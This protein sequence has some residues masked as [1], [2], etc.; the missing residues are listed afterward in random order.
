MADYIRIVNHPDRDKIIKRL[1]EGDPPRT[2]GE[3]LR[4]RYD[5][6]DEVHLRLPVTLLKEFKDNYLKRHKF[7]DRIVKGDQRD[8][9][10]KKIAESL[11]NNKSWRQRLEE[12][13]EKEVDFKNKIQQLC[14]LVEAR[15]EQVFDQIQRDPTTFKGDYVLINYIDKLTNL[16]EK[17]N[18]LVND[19]PDTLIQNNI[20]IQ[21]VEHHS[22][23]FQD[24]IREVI[25]ELDPETS[26]LVMDKLNEKL[27]QLKPEKSPTID[28]KLN[29]TDKMLKSAESVEVIDD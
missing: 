13:V 7:L 22:M 16:L 17:G 1:L 2:I 5:G 9:I 28:E 6:K 24:A 18:K 4:L 19:I 11:M 10:D 23:I 8:I 26:N 15:V 27:N 3:Y 25:A 29:T 21:M 14:I 12:S 20:S